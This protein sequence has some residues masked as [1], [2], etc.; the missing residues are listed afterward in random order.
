[1]YYLQSRYY[2][3][4]IGRFINA[5][6]ILGENTGM[7][8]YDLYCYCGNSPVQ[9][10]DILG[11]AWLSA[12]LKVVAIAVAVVVTVAHVVNGVAALT[13]ADYNRQH[14]TTKLVTDQNLID[15]K[16]GGSWFADQGCGAAAVHNAI[17]LAGGTSSLAEVV[18][19]MQ[20]HDLTLGFA[21]VYFT[22]MQLYLKRKGY[23]NKVYL[24]K[25][26]NKLDSKIKAC[27]KQIAILAYKHS[28][29]GHYVAIKYSSEDKLFHI[30][31]DRVPT[32]PSVDDFISKKKYK[33]LCLITLVK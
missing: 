11:C 23:R 29:S 1:M 8:A 9:R 2:D 21:G 32:V 22:N 28:S 26:R 17:I 20:A 27:K 15:M 16:M 12:V 4:Q 33:P 31:N 5:D 25:L 7:Q 6:S 14:D 19:F 13:Q 24:T 30:Y 3:P 18:R 10:I